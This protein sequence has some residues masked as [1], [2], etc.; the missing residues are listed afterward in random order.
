M[1]EMRTMAI[2]VDVGGSGIKAAAVDTARG[3]LVS[4]RIRVPTPQPSTPASVIAAI[5]RVVRRIETAVGSSDIPVGVDLP[6]VILGGKTMT[7]ANV[8]PGW[9]GYPAAEDIGKG[10]GRPITLVNDADAAGLAEMRFG[11]GAGRRG[12]VL[13]LTLGTG[14]GSGLFVDGVLV[15]NTELGQM[16]IR[17]RDAERRSAAAARIR[18]GISWKAWTADLDEHLHAMDRILWPDLIILGGG[19]SKNADRF[20]PR[21]TCRPPVVAAV[22]RNEAG[23]VG[24]A[25]FAIEAGAA[26]AAIPG[27]GVAAAG[28]GGGVAA[29]GGGAE[30]PTSEPEPEMSAATA[31]PGDGGGGGAGMDGA[32]GPASDAEPDA[33]AAPEPEPDAAAAPEPEPDVAAAAAPEPDE[34]ATLDPDSAAAV[35]S[36]AARQEPGTLADAWPAAGTLRVA[37]RW[38]HAPEWPPEPGLSTQHPGEPAPSAAGPLAPG[39]AEAGPREA[40]PSAPASE[41]VVVA[42]SGDA[43]PAASQGA[44]PDPAR[45]PENDATVSSDVT[46]DDRRPNWWSRANPFR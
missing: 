2:G 15:P 5:I 40:P 29:A 46:D 26:G 33:A 12:V 13:V 35:A 9:I 41:G 3:T 18:R 17:G 8:D 32:E 31:V 19:V 25:M 30:G 36:E 14:V 39:G 24:A 23:M 34:A 11:A 43:V 38:T 42:T 6:S 20:I 45:P 1:S 21:L 16:E 27:V 28:G 7:A 44:V 37:E 10:L 22:L 4:D